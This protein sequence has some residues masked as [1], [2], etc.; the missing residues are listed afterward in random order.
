MIKYKKTNDEQQ[1]ESLSI[2]I[3]FTRKLILGVFLL[4]LFI[5]NMDSCNKTTTKIHTDDIEF[6]E[7][8]GEPIYNDSYYRKFNN[9]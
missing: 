8:T 7:L 3:R 2:K 6:N 4:F 5:V 1:K 9:N